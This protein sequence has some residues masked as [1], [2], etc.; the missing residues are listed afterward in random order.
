MSDAAAPNPDSRD[1]GFLKFAVALNGSRSG[2]RL[3]GDDISTLIR[4]SDLA[5][6]HMQADDPETRE[7]IETNLSYLDQHAV[8]AL[9]AD[10][11]R[12]RLSEI[13]KG[14]LVILRGVNHNAGDE[15][16][17]MVSIRIWIDENRIISVSKRGL[18]SVDNLV[19][20]VLGGRGP[21]RA[22]GFLCDLITQLTQRIEHFRRDI[23]DRTDIVEE[24]LLDAPDAK[25]R[26]PILLLRQQTIA[27]RRYIAPQRDS[28]GELMRSGLPWL[29]EDDR[30]HLHERHNDHLRIV[31]DLDS[32]RERLQILKDEIASAMSERLN[33]NLYLLSVVTALF[34]PL[35]F[36][37]GLFGVNL[38]GMPGTSNMSAFTIL[39]ACL[40]V[41]GLLQMLIF[42]LLRWI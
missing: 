36:L 33:R 2:Q 34:L 24:T 26:H 3:T 19:A 15:P 42:R 14:A 6:V 5:W 4:A 30:R 13:G 23:D 16:E 39:V 32:I 28:L 29:S 31:E 38:A 8:D 25:L 37:T 9:L 10:E 21:D 20:S 17:D 1:T 27:F 22:G 18:L 35:G 11:T 40:V 7:W 41:I 12:P